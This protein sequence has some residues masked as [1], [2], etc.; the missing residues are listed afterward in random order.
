MHI[1]M[2]SCRV[3]AVTIYP[4]IELITSLC[5]LNS[6]ITKVDLLRSI[7]NETVFCL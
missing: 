6:Q 4:M 1:W 7:N 3:C 2:G 5:Y